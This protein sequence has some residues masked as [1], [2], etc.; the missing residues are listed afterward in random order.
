MDIKE[1]LG[2]YVETIINIFTLVVGPF[3]IAENIVQ[4]F[5]FVVYVIIY[6]G[7]LGKSNQT[8][9]NPPDEPFRLTITM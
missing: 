7:I 8:L 1:M 2:I 5:F 3:F 9:S 6:Y 4:H